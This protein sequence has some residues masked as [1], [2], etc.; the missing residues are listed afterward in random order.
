MQWQL[1]C[2]KPNTS[3]NLEK[4]VYFSVGNVGFTNSS[5]HG[6]ET[7]TESLITS[8]NKPKGKKKSSWIW[9]LMEE[10]EIV[11]DGEKSKGVIC[12]VNTSE[13]SDIIVHCNVVVRTFI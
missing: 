2:Q 9:N 4:Y 3:L 12:R 13:F 7:M 10:T 1:F 5:K 8:P 11:K 6:M